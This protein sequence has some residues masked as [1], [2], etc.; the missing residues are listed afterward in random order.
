MSYASIDDLIARFGE[1][2]LIQSTGTRLSNNA[3]VLDEEKVTRALNDADALINTYLQKRYVIP[4]VPVPDLL[5]AIASNLARYYLRTRSENSG[6]I[7]ETVK[8]RFDEAMRQLCELRDGK[9]LLTDVP[10]NANESGSRV[11]TNK[12]PQVF[13]GSGCGLSGFRG[14]LDPRYIGRRRRGQW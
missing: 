7:S 2:E 9:I 1:D 8:D 4:V 11:L 5:I 3:R 6:K 10:T 14:R 12:G 13:S